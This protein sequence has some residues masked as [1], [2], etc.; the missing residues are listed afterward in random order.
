MRIPTLLAAAMTASAC[1]SV[2]VAE[3]DSPALRETIVPLQWRST[4]EEYHFAP[5]VRAGDYV[6]LSGVVAAPV[7][8]GTNEEAFEAGYDRAFAVIAAV[9]AEADAEWSD[10]VD[11]TTYHT[12]LPAQFEVFARVKDRYVPEPYPAW[13]AIDVDRLLLD[14]GVVEIRVIAYAPRD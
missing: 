4:Y 6:F 11:I 8:G 7:G 1:V 10:V 14:E 5:A 12:D 13:T 2:D 9:L 3:T